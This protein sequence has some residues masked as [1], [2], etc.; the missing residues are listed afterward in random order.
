MSTAPSMVRVSCKAD[1]KT[2]AVGLEVQGNG[3]IAIRLAVVFNPDTF[4]K[5]EWLLKMAA[6]LQSALLQDYQSMFNPPYSC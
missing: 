4:P 5:V 2:D 6:H 1:R 3:P